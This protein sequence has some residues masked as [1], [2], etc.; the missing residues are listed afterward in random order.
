MFGGNYAPAGWALCQGQV[1]SIAANQALFSLIGTTYGGDGVNTFN[2]PDLRGRVPVHQGANPTTHTPYPIG[3][4]GGSEQVTLLSSQLPAHAHAAQAQSGNGTQ[5]G[6]G[7]AVWAT[8][9][10][11]NL[12]PFSTNASP[13]GVMN[14]AC[15]AAA[16]NNQ[17]HENRMPFLAINFIIAMEGIYPSRG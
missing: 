12:R 8:E 3:Q 5:A 6:P 11:P 4:A 1:V 14:Q 7:N 9:L 13:S 16:G 17:P 10:D 2:L 15:L